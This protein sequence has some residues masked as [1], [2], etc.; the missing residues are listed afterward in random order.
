MELL[1]VLLVHMNWYIIIVSA[2]VLLKFTIYNVK[3]RNFRKLKL[4]W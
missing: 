4:Q 2:K 3:M 1:R